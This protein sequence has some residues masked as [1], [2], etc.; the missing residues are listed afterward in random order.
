MKTQLIACLITVI[1][2]FSGTASA[3]VIS[4]TFTGTV[5]MVID[6]EPCPLD[7]IISLDDAVQGMLTYDPDT[8]DVEANENIG[9]Y[10]HDGAPSGFSATINGHTFRTDPDDYQFDIFVYDNLAGGDRFRVES[11]VTVPDSIDLDP[12]CVSTTS[13][14]PMEL[15][16]N[17]TQTA[18]SSDS[19]PTD[20]VLSDWTDA[21]AAVTFGESGSQ[22][23]LQFEIDTLEPYIE[24]IA[25]GWGTP[26]S[27]VGA[28]FKGSSDI[29]NCL[30]LL[31]L[32]V[33][34]VIAMRIIRRKR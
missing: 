20:L 1:L 12:S 28:E 2:L 15:V 22:A 27:I 23:Y 6:S 3:Q 33:G 34:T 8:L 18:L 25:S 14:L 10:P 5:T 26:A 32:P 4:Y 21:T 24:P 31:S 16:D 7:G 11:S 13:F 29:V 19:L 9:E 30:F 17:D